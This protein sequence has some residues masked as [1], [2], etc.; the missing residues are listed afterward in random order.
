MMMLIIG[1]LLSQINFKTI[2]S[3]AYVYI[4]SLL[5]LV[6]VPLLSFFLLRFAGISGI[7]LQLCVICAATPAAANTAIF[8]SRYDGDT[9]LASRAVSVSTLLS[10]ITLMVT[11]ILVAPY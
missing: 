3:G 1:S 4:G 8:A 6:V 9:S 5:R 10:I 2:F 7:P 11:I